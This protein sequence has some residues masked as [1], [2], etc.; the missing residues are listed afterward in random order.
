MKKEITYE[1]LIP[2]LGC[3]SKGDFVEFPEGSQEL[4]KKKNGFPGV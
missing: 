2:V 4:V 1:G 3:K